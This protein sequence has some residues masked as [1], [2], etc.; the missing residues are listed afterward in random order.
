MVA[1]LHDQSDIQEDCV[2]IEMDDIQPELD[3]WQSSIYCQVI[4]VNPPLNV[5][6]G[7]FRRIWK[8]NGVDKIT[9][10]RKGIFLVRFKTMENCE[11]VQ[12][13]PIPYF[14]SKPVLIKKWTPDGDVTSRDLMT[15]PIWIHSIGWRKV[16]RGTPQQK[17]TFINS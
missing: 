11:K 13:E 17:V 4:G 7:Y 16:C 3:Y 1:E 12:R 8:H 9:E 14:D 10:I 15:I 6:E 2:K 5:A